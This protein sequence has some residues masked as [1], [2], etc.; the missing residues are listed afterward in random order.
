MLGFLRWICGLSLAV[1]LAYFAV[2]NQHVTEI[3]Y[4]PLHAPLALPVFAIALGFCF[5]GFFMGAL[6]VWFNLGGLRSQL[7]RQKKDLKSLEKQLSQAKETSR[8]EAPASDF[9]PALPKR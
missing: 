2:F 9:F 3:I 1:L 7:H 4:S 6:S 5:L 8:T